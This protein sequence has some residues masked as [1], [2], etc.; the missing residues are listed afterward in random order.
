MSTNRNNGNKTTKIVRF[1][2]YGDADSL[3]FEN[4]P[5][6]EPGPDEVRI[7]VE[8]MSLNR[9]DILFRKNT[10]FIDATLPESRIGMDAAGVIEAVGETVEGFQLGDR[11]LTWVGFDVSKYG[12]HGETAIIPAAF[13]TKYPDFLTPI[14]AA[15]ITATYTTVYGALIE[16][17]ELKQGDHVLITAASS[18]VGVA[19]IQVVNAVGAIPIAATRSAAKKQAL[20]DAGAAHVVVTDDMKLGEAVLEITGGRGAEFI[21]D[22]IAV[23]ILEELSMAA[24]VGATIV[25]YGTLGD[26]GPLGQMPA[27]LP[28]LPLLGKQFN[29]RGYNNYALSGDAERRQRALDWVTEGIRSGKL[30]V[31]VAK[32]FKFNKYAD[33]HRYL[34]SNE[35][36]GRVVVHI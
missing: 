32:S 5:L 6:A 21:F 36:I 33:A 20:L 28:L 30:K 16:D 8:G 2:K 18:S 10:Y 27:R 7:R 1:D 31:A 26:S 4:I 23:G 13:V 22:P 25:I 34:E 12:V 15:S 29:I 24:A 14:E 9:A 17:G 35:Q 19:A 11:V 3:R